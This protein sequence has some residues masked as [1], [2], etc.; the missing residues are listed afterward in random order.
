[1]ELL[2]P[3]GQLRLT[4]AIV[5]GN[6]QQH[7]RCPR[8]AGH[9]TLLSS[10][11]SPRSKQQREHG[12][13][14]S[15]APR[16]HLATP[17]QSSLRCHLR[18]GVHPVRPMGGGVTEAAGDVAGACVEGTVAAELGPGLWVPQLPWQCGHV[19]FWIKTVGALPLLSKEP[20]F[21]H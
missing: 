17:W 10:P 16:P 5:K 6:S 20:L 13:G 18:D 19:A 12:P 15:A 3:S 7:L 1:M 21:P 11:A 4:S 14:S 9:Q 8:W 2:G